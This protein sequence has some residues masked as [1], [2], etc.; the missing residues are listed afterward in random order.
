MAIALVNSTAAVRQEAARWTYRVFGGFL[1]NLM[2][3]R[4]QHHMYRAIV[5]LD[6]P[7]VLADMQAACGRFRT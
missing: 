2:A 5:D 4:R 3:A 7:G 6:H 1:L